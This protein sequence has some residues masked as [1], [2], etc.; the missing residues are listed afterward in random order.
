VL[1]GTVKFAVVYP[2]PDGQT[3]VL[4]GRGV[5]DP[6]FDRLV[7]I[8]SQGEVLAD[9]DATQPEE[10]PKE[11]EG[12]PVTRELTRLAGT[13]TEVSYVMMGQKV[14]TSRSGPRIKL[15]IPGASGP[16]SWAFGPPKPAPERP[17][18]RLIYSLGV[19]E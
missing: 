14:D 1:K 8:D 19:G 15:E 7:V 6:P 16:S 12:D 4:R 18:T 10:Q 11:E 17:L 2:S 13:W 9:I 3:L 5:P